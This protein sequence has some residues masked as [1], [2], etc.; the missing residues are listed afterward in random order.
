MGTNMFDAR[1]KFKT[2]LNDDQLRL[3]AAQELER[4]LQM[5]RQSLT[6]LKEHLNGILEL[7]QAI[8]TDEKGK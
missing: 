3:I 8:D 7:A 1:L 2:E 4:Q 6:D 5:A